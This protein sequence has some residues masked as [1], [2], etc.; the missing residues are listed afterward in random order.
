V[1]RKKSVKKLDR[2]EGRITVVPGATNDPEVIKKAA[3]GCDGVLTVLVPWGVHQYSSG[4]AQAV[5]D[6]AHRSARLIFSSGWH[7]TRDGKDVYSRTFKVVLKAISWLGR[8]IRTVEL[9]DQ[10]EAC[11]RLSAVRRP[12][13][14]L[15]LPT[16]ELFQFCLNLV[17]YLRA[18]HIRTV[19][20]Q[21]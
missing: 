5:L 17:V 18:W 21:T 2:F 6:Y 12:Q 1:C 8:L 9:D 4:T 16:N 11:R 3:A 14:S 19:S 15:T 13:R 20:T 7:I 10:V